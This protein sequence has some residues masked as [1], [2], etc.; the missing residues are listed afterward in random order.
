MVTTLDKRISTQFGIQDTVEFNVNLSSKNS[1]F[2]L[3]YNNLIKYLRSYLYF[4]YVLSPKVIFLPK[5]ITCI[6]NVIKEAS[7]VVLL[8]MFHCNL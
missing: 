1:N 7:R 4:M 6:S 2:H 8:K 3:S 5:G